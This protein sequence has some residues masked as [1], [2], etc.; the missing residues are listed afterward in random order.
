M[1]ALVAR[2]GDEFPLSL[3]EVDVSSDPQLEDLYGREVPVL[4]LEG[5]KVAKYRISE[6]E[7]RRVLQA[8]VAGP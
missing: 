4:I 6:E 2:I 7:L 1:K 3:Q 8:K 5:K